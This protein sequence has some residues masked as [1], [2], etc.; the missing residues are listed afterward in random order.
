MR[1]YLKKTEVESEFS[2]RGFKIQRNRHMKL[3]R[4]FDIYYIYLQNYFN[5][6]KIKF[7]VEEGL[8]PPLVQGDG[9]R[10]GGVG[11]R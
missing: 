3:R 8:A 4:E 1:G 9:V 11:D 7:F 6:I 5:F 10:I 2:V